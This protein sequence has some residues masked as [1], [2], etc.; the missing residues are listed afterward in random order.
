VKGRTTKE[1]GS[2]NGAGCVGRSKVLLDLSK[3]ASAALTEDSRRISLQREQREYASNAPRKIETWY[4]E[5]GHRHFPRGAP[6]EKVIRRT[7]V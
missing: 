5:Q 4:E 7:D 1:H 6:R 3:T 2:D